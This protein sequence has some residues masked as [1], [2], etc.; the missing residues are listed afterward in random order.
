MMLLRKASSFAPAAATCGAVIATGVALLGYAL[1][2][3]LFV[4]R[5][6]APAAH[7]YTR[8]LHFDYTGY[9]AVAEARLSPNLRETPGAGARGPL[10]ATA[11]AVL[12]KSRFLPSGAQVVVNVRLYIPWHHTDLFQLTGELLTNTS[13]VAARSVRTHIN[14]PQPYVFYLAK[15][16][17]FWPFYAVGWGT[18]EWVEV[19][20]PLFEGYEERHDEPV[21]ALRATLASRNASGGGLPPPPVHHADL[22]VRLR[23]GPVETLLYWLRPGLALSLVIGLLGLTAGA[24]GTLAALALAVAACVLRRWVD[25]DA[26]EKAGKRRRASHGER[27]VGGVAVAASLPGA[28]PSH[29]KARSGGAG[30]QGRYPPPYGDLDDALSYSLGHAELTRGGGGDGGINAGGTIFRGPSP[31]PFS[32]A[33]TAKAGGA[34]HVEDYDESD[35]GASV[36]YNSHQAYDGSGRGPT[37]DS[38]VWTSSAGSVYGAAAA[39]VAAASGR[40]AS[41]QDSGAASGGVPSRSASGAAAAS[42]QPARPGRSATQ[43]PSPVPPPGPNDDGEGEDAD[44][45]YRGAGTEAGAGGRAGPAGEGGYEDASS[46]GDS[47]VAGQDPDRGYEAGS[48]EVGEGPGEHGEG[49]EAEVLEDAC[50]GGGAG[51]GAEEPCQPGDVGRRKGPEG[52]AARRR[53]DVAPQADDQAAGPGVRRRPGFFWAA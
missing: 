34:R 23:L 37:A 48:S 12:P 2:G 28:A 17:M 49:E 44:V 50:E 40:P 38:P 1:L 19:R 5:H 15:Q 18:A 26:K 14:T 43:S 21:T 33:A 53:G 32:K 22:D 30:S 45:A 36:P 51:A 20:L 35:D 13:H 31:G 11:A 29:R 10:P 24:G 47:A 6:F 42:G 25:A 16:A 52:E 4:T 39:A 27:G 3:F 8:P 9:T 46:V 7:H 41:R